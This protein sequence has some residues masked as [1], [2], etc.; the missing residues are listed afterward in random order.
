[1]WSFIIPSVCKGLN[2]LD[3]KLGDV[4]DFAEVSQFNAKAGEM[5]WNVGKSILIVRNMGTITSEFEV[6]GM[7][8][9][10]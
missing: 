4:L 6:T 5:G 3:S 1:M 8:A 10:I 2:M 9:V 7:E